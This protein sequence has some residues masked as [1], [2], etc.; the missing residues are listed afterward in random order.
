[1]QF[2][3][4]DVSFSSSNIIPS[5]TAFNY[6]M[7]A[8]NRTSFQHLLEQQRAERGVG[9]GKEQPAQGTL[10]REDLIALRDS[11]SAQG[12]SADR[13]K[14][15]N[16]LAESGREVTPDEV[17]KALLGIELEDFDTSLTFDLT[18]LEKGEL[19]GLLSKLGFSHDE[20]SG[21]MEEL[22]QG[23]DVNAWNLLESK[24]EALSFN[25]ILDVSKRE[26]SALARAFRLSE[27]QRAQLEGIFAEGL[28]LNSVALGDALSLLKTEMVNR[29]RSDMLL[30]DGKVLQETLA[31]VLSLSKS[32]REMTDRADNRQSQMAQRMDTRIKDSVNAQGETLPQAAAN[33]EKD[34]ADGLMG[35]NLRDGQQQEDLP[36]RE[37][38]EQ[39]Y[40]TGQK[41]GNAETVKSGSSE[42]ESFISRVISADPS[43]L[44]SSRPQTAEGA[45]A[46][47]A[48]FANSL[49]Q[50]VEQGLLKTI[51]DG[52]KQLTLQLEPGDLGTV[53]LVVS[54][55]E[56]EV[57]AIIRPDSL[58][59]AKLVEEQLHR[60]R[61]ALE[62]QGLKVDNLEVQSNV[63]ERDSQQHG[64][65]GMEK[66]NL[67]R[68][69]LEYRERARL[70]HRLRQADNSLAQEMH[71]ISAEQQNAAN[72]SRSEI[73]IV[74]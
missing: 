10:N 70:L 39:Q 44:G 11:L 41:A 69:E 30:A 54:V 21:F 9:L 73:Y 43:I 48:S 15:L 45:R 36:G 37:K 28:S 58:E 57:N 13:L 4:A 47:A 61:Q 65:N 19:H 17:I 40:R 67:T 5:M 35:R 38:A 49:F 14:R 7:A 2:L 52:I 29:S 16:A 26:I 68:Q 18:D 50:Q 74:A 34:G 32:R 25:Q 1:M 55:H 46:Q 59:A 27:G 31:D 66:H 56:R 3:P 24:L 23:G 12:I 53:T 51:Q 33:L 62:S 20:I 60:I 64:W 72:F 63:A 6:D 42:S 8:Q 71:N 22:A